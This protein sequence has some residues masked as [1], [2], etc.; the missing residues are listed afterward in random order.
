MTA[1][2]DL[3]YTFFRWHRL[4][5]LSKKYWNIAKSHATSPESIISRWSVSTFIPIIIFGV[6]HFALA[7]CLSNLASTLS[8]HWQPKLTCDT[9]II[10]YLNKWKPHK[11][12]LC[13]RGRKMGESEQ[14]PPHTRMKYQNRKSVLTEK[15][16]KIFNKIPDQF[17]GNKS[18]VVC[19]LS[20]SS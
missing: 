16:K 20:F 7:T 1:E 15:K 4:A 9:H 10:I 13:H 18:L 3:S 12:S 17:V 11:I 8:L 14:Q 19:S 2:T 5:I 6:T